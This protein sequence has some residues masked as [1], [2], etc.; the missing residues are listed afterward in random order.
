MPALCNGGS[1]SIGRE[2][3]IKRRDVAARPDTRVATL[4]Y[5][6]HTRPNSTLQSLIRCRSCTCGLHSAYFRGEA[7]A[8][9]RGEFHTG[10]TGGRSSDKDSRRQ[11]A[12]GA[13]G[14]MHACGSC[15]TVI[16]AMRSQ[17]TRSKATA[18]EIQGAPGPSFQH[19]P[20]VQ[21]FVFTE[22]SFG[23]F[24]HRRQCVRVQTLARFLLLVGERSDCDT[25]RAG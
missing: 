1:E 4:R 15:H 23:L 21:Q 13:R 25:S 7:R 9:R 2:S 18:R 3:R 16:G 22:L 12:S 11:G 20:T 6:R 8:R 5:A 17:W 19:L 14:P 10:E 24:L